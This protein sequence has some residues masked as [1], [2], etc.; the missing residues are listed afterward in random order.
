[1]AEQL[2]GEDK[3]IGEEAI[4][5]ALIFAALGAAIGSVAIPLDVFP[6]FIHY[7][8]G[9]G[10]TPTDAQSAAYLS[11][12]SVVW[13]AA[14]T[15][16]LLGLCLM[17]AG[18]GFWLFGWQAS[19]W[20]FNGMRFYKDPEEGR[21]IMQA[22]ENKLMSEAQRK[23]EIP[24]I[25]IGGVSFSNTRTAGQISLVGIPGSGK[26]VIINSAL[27]QIMQRR[28]RVILHDPKGDFTGWLYNERDSVMLGPW[29]ERARPWDISR[30]ICEPEIAISFAQS[31]VMPSE[32]GGG[33]NQFFYDAA[34]ETIGG[35]IMFYQR[36][37]GDNWSWDTLCSDLTKGPKHL[38]ELAKRGSPNNKTLLSGSI[39][40]GALPSIMSTVAN[41][42]SWILSY[43]AAFPVV[44]DADDKLDRPASGMF[45]IQ[46]WLAKRENLAIQ[47][48]FLN[49]NKNYE[50]R[51]AQIFGAII[52]S[53]ANYINSSE[54]PEVSA[55]A[56]GLWVVLDEY[57]QLGA[58]VS[59]YIQQIEELGRSRG[60]RVLKAIQD[61]A[62]LFAQVGRDKG[63]A[64]K[65]VQQTRIYCKLATGTASELSRQ[66]GQK[67][68]VRIEFPQVLGQGNKRVVHDKADVI[69]VSDLTGLRVIKEGV[70]KDRGIEMVI[71]TDDILVKL[72]QPFIAAEIVKE[73]NAKVINNEKYITG[74]FKYAEDAE[75]KAAES[76]AEATPDLQPEKAGTSLPAGAVSIFGE[77]DEPEADGGIVAS[78][79]PFTAEEMAGFGSE[80]IIDSEEEIDE[81]NPS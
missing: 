78:D 3:L 57:P 24:S 23:G 51:A 76:K 41:A 8:F 74:I 16:F 70:E 4:I 9:L 35:L 52:A 71:H 81:G 14:A 60:V 63:Q 10:S 66:L 43:G 7:H 62:Q 13:P 64:Q 65:S 22:N 18:Y 6:A 31:L 45:S 11:L 26:T 69:R 79:L 30:D 75:A 67:D 29:D 73:R 46:S 44:R 42:T 68:I 48:V 50:A 21:P 34:R 27:Y 80:E 53:A 28:E 47:K 40:K 77:I 33:Q 55:D 38:I 12:S 58:T 59:K 5:G 19:Q 15:F 56:A 17:L 61:E 25:Q 2:Y 37:Q 49:N 39:D 54:M 1:M 72:V 32:G 36:T 20:H